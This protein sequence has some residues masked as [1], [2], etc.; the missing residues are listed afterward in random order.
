[1]ASMAPFP[2]ILNLSFPVIYSKKL[3]YGKN[4]DS[5][6][7]N[8][9]MSSFLIVNGKNNLITGINKFSLMLLQK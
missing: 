3:P 2:G 9:K 5:F 6:L 4:K 1:M 8:N 7:V